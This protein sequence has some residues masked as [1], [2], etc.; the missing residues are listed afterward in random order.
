MISQKFNPLCSFRFRIALL[1]VV[2]SG[3]VLLG[4]ATWV[5]R[6]MQTSIL[7]QADRELLGVAQRHLSHHRPS[8]YW[9]DVADSW[10]FIWGDEEPRGPSLLV[11][12]HE[13]NLVFK[14]EAW[15]PSLTQSLLR[16]PEP[17]RS[18]RSER[19]TGHERRL[20]RSRIG[21]VPERMQGEESKPQGPLG[22]S[23][24]S[25][26]GAPRI[27]RY[28]VLVQ[29][30]PLPLSSLS[31]LEHAEGS[32]AWR[33][34]VMRNPEVTLA[35]AIPLD[36]FTR[37]IKAL[38]RSF[39]FATTAALLLIALGGVWLA[40]SA[41]QPVYA[42]TLAMERVTAQRLDQRIPLQGADPE[43]GRLIL[44]FNEMLDRLHSSFSQA[45]R[46]SADAA[47]ELKTPLT[48]LQG[49]LEQALQQAPAGSAQQ[50][51]LGQLMDS[52]QRL[53]TITRKLL[54]LALADAGCLDLHMEPLDLSE[55]LENFCDDLRILAAGIDVRCSIAP[56]IQVMVDRDLFSQVLQNL[57]SNA[58]KYNRVGG[59]ICLR[60]GAANG[61]ARLA[62]SNSG[63]G[64]SPK[65]RARIFDRF[66]RGDRTRAPDGLGLGLS[67]AREIVRAH[68]GELVLEQTGSDMTTFQLTLPT[69]QH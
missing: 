31:L 30:D 39:L 66:H 27:L 1:S 47:H 60:L 6:L 20:F 25:D 44:V 35:L 65:Q 56:D 18:E 10:E 29:G 46:F 12:D 3:L 26:M 58:V 61:S 22:G 68:H 19:E 11:W 59:W 37:E 48:V 28:R 38:R 23:G 2:V 36:R 67:L 42:L 53:K 69:S 5:F 57:A 14:S 64:I 4:F 41:F 32:T 24:N 55:E 43:F 7:E 34:G 33:I 21:L 63:P 40:R 45:T 13:N 17:P 50:E 15:P 8:G 52:V 62:I 51:M 9:A 49:E 16:I 54:L